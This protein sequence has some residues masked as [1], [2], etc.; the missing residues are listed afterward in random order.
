MICEIKGEKF[1][2]KAS[3]KLKA[4]EAAAKVWARGRQARYKCLV[5]IGDDEFRVFRRCEQ[6]TTWKGELL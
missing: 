4:A 5:I 3:T 1:D 2:V 6:V